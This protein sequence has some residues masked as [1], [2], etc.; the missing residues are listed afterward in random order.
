MSGYYLDALTPVPNP[1]ATVQALVPAELLEEIT[2][3]AAREGRSPLDVVREALTA[4]L[5]SA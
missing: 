1:H 3:R 5:R 2:V 4:Y